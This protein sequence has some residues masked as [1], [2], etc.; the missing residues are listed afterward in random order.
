M[1]RSRTPSFSIVCGA[2]SGLDVTMP[3]A[4]VGRHRIRGK[5]AVAID[6]CT[7]VELR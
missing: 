7:V 4:E 1:Q 2:K 6:E 5:V 3:Q